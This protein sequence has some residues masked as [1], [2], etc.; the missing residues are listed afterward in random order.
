[1][2]LQWVVVCVGGAALAAGCGQVGERIETLTR[3]ND[4]QSAMIAELTKAQQTMRLEVDA[5][6]REQAASMENRVEALVK[7]VTAR[8]EQQLA[9]ATNLPTTGTDRSIIRET[10]QAELA[11]TEARKKAAEEA[12]AAEEQ[13]QRDERRA[14][15]ENDRW[16][17]L[18]K[19]LNLS[20][21]QRQQFQLASSNVRQVIR[22]TMD[23]MRA[24]GQDPDPAAIKL[25]SERL[26]NEYTATLSQI[27]T[28]EQIDAY[29]KQPNNMLH[30]M[31][32]MA[33]NGGHMH[34]HGGGGPGGGG[35]PPQ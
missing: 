35:G 33:Q 10:V 7:D 14:Q 32:E 18:Q 8:V 26:R 12:K 3:Q 1:M 9:T 22:D 13:K 15:W 34:F 30:M 19:D 6:R 2:R 5:L 31:D 17:S 24:S 23:K 11:A 21:D 28:P 4:E 29:R 27:L 16:N 25:A 20:D